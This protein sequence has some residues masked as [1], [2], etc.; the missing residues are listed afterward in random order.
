MTRA[1]EKKLNVFLH[2]GLHRI[3]KIYLSM[4]KTN[5]ETEIKAESEP[6]SKQGAKKSWKLLGL[7]L[8][9]DHLLHVRIARTWL[10]ENRRNRG[11]PGKTSRRTAERVLKEKWLVF[12]NKVK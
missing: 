11:R 3:L 9:M 6:V 1:D 2:K 7:I 10:P 4:R 5:E 12:F 8:R